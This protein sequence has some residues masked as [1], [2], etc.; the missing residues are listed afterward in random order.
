MITI[1]D[2]LKPEHVLLDLEAANPREAIA[3]TAA[4]LRRDARVRDWEAFSKLLLE[5]APCRAATAVGVG[6]C[7]PH[8]RT[9]GVTGII[10][11]AARLSHDLS[12]AE[13]GTPIRYIFCL[14]VPQALSADYLRIAGALMRIVNDQ[15]TEAKIHGAATRPEFVEAMGEFEMK[16]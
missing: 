11:S 15:A 4:L 2:A 9:D 5:P 8:A 16:L 13:C 1:P 3:A 10:M 12:F 14:G 6:L 7:L